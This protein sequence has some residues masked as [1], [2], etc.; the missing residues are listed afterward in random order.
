MPREVVFRANSGDNTCRARR[1]GRAR[2]R[3]TF[4]DEIFVVLAV[5][6]RRTIRVLVGACVNPTLAIAL[7]SRGNV[8]DF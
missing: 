3:T 8:G 4:I 1:V 7:G 5:L 6:A 2:C